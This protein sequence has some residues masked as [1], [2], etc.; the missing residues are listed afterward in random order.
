MTTLNAHQPGRA[1]RC[2][3]ILALVAGL[4]AGLAHAQSLGAGS[5]THDRP[6]FSHA[7]FVSNIPG[8]PG[9]TVWHLPP[10]EQERGTLG[11]ARLA[12]TLRHPPIAIAAADHKVYLFFEDPSGVPPL[13]PRQVLSIGASRQ[14]TESAWRTEPSGRFEVLPSLRADGR[15]VDAVNAAGTLWVLMH[16]LR[17]NDADPR[18]L[19]LLRLHA[20][21]WKEVPL[22]S[23]A[24]AAARA[25][26]TTE[27]GAAV[28]LGAPWALVGG[29]DQLGLHLPPTRDD[30]PHTFWF[31][32]HG[33]PTDGDEE[34]F[35]WSA[36]QRVQIEGSPRARTRAFTDRGE[37]FIITAQA[38][39]DASLWRL[40]LSPE[41]RATPVRLATAGLPGADWVAIPRTPAGLLTLI[42]TPPSG[43]SP[44]EQGA[45]GRAAVDISLRTGRVLYR[46]PM[47]AASPIT[48]RDS[49]LVI[50]IFFSLAATVA[51]FV[52]R[53]PGERGVAPLP[54]GASM[55]GMARRVIATGVDGLLAL[56]LAATLSRVPLADLAAQDWW[57]SAQPWAVVPLALLALVLF[58]ALAES[59]GGRT[60]G[61]MLSGCEVVSVTPGAAT[62]GD[63]A[64]PPLAASLLR[65]AIKWLVPLIALL[66]LF[67]LS[68]RHRGDEW[69]RA[70]VVVRHPP[71]TDEE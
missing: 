7:W 35:E 5:P 24:A 62:N 3:A 51:L 46:G 48:S 36:D 60:P 14:P 25:Q 26:T 59:A 9:A 34:T 13:R 43:A 37:L 30:D 42:G 69:A 2:A 49:R 1:A 66:G 29:P 21:A 38:G 32:S 68:R 10:P 57:K 70:A 4:A 56:A 52:L 20:G 61:K 23:Q 58:G 11:R 55:A 8:R 67:D 47:V 71:M 53:P 12:T 50:T 40:P 22:P 27:D 19:V 15:V 31:L 63:W 18:R 6:G 65:H 17:D 16:A 44:G 33:M 64:R 28:R 45:A 54:A 39:G 41:A